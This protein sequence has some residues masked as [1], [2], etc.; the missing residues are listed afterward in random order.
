MLLKISEDYDINEVIKVLQ[1][2]GFGDAKKTCW[3]TELIECEI[4][5]RKEN[6]SK[7]YSEEAIKKTEEAFREILDEDLDG[8]A[9]DNEYL[10]RKWMELLEE[11]SK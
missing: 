10:S 5:Y 7:E 4:E 8:T 11:Y 2:N 3:Q 9:I 6:D 1:E